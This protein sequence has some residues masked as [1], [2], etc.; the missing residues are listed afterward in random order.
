MTPKKALEVLI[1]A[2]QCYAPC[3]RL[4]PQE[5]EAIKILRDCIKESEGKNELRRVE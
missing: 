2:L 1:Y 3:G 5:R 4:K